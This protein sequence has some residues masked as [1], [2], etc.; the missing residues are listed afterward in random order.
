PAI[1]AQQAERLARLRADRDRAAVDTA[2][3]ALK[4]AAEG[5]DNVLYPMKDAL[6]ARAT[7]GE[8]CHALREVWGTYVPTDA[9]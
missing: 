7:V 5:T 6:K 3:A 9:F 2:L 4:K 8:V 1:E